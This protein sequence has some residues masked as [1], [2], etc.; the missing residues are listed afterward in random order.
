M[1]HTLK[2]LA[3]FLFAISLIILTIVSCKQAQKE[4]PIPEPQPVEGCAYYIDDFSLPQTQSEQ[5][6]A[7]YLASEHFE[8]D[9]DGWFFFGTVMD[10]ATQ[11]T[12]IFFIAIQRIEM[13]SQGIKLPVVPAI[14]AFNSSK[15]GKY[16]YRGEFTLDIDPF[17]TV[18]SNPWNVQ[19]K[20]LLQTKPLLE[21]SLV[22]GTMGAAGAVYLLS[23]DISRPTGVNLKADVKIRDRFGT[24]NEGDGNASF[25]AQ[26]LT[27]AQREDILESPDHTVAH[28]LAT[29]GDPMNCQGSYYYSL[30]L[31]DVE[32]FTISLADTLVSSGNQ[33]LMWMDYVVQS[34]DEAAQ[35]VF[36]D[37]SWNFFAIQFPALDA[38]LM[39]IEIDSETGLLPIAKYFSPDSELTLNK[40]HTARH[41]WGINDINIE[42]VPGSEWTSPQS[43]EKYYMK[44]NIQLS[45]A[46]FPAFLTVTMIR[47]NQEIVINDTTVKYEGIARVEGTINGAAV[48]GQ[49]FVEIQPA[50][51][52][53]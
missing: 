5:L 18:E 45:S 26:Y 40:A 24:I 33:G 36:S 48:S 6:L 35:E 20:S 32:S 27:A 49:A 53:K 15:L 50:G 29:T 17:M 1:T 41:N 39:V 38:S 16:E 37:A 47:N 43:G 51:H 42:V 12:G 11:D 21:L 52:L 13:G 46:E 9:L 28:Y 19:V 30:P 2:T 44:H 31:L 8:Y 23:A 7:E 10:A 22:S 3:V 25:F 4:D 14:V 34:Y